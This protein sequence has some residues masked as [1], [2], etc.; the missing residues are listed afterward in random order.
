MHY[1]YFI[2][3]SVKWIT[4]LDLTSRHRS[5]YSRQ[6]KVLSGRGKNQKKLPS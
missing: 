4:K 5:F 2:T 1:E 6:K 3:I